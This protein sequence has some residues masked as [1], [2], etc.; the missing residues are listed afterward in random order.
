M[1]RFEQWLDT[2]LAA[3]DPPEGIDAE[4]LAAL[5]GSTGESDTGA[6]FTP[7]TPTRC[8]PR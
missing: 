5:A 3:E 7:A 2:A 1:R 6:W 4:L 8:G